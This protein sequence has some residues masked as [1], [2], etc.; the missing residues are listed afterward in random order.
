[1]GLFNTADEERQG[2]IAGPSA[3]KF[4]SRSRLPV[5]VLKNI[6][7]VADNPPSNFLDHR[8]FA[9]AIR[10]IQLAQNGLKGEGANLAVPGGAVLK[11]AFFEGI[12]GS[13]V[14][15]PPP[16]PQQQ[17]QQ[18]QQQLHQQ[19]QAPV[20]PSRQP[21]QQQP[22][23][24]PTQHPPPGGIPSSPSLQSTQMNHSA[25][26]QPPTP[27]RPPHP[28]SHPVGP[29]VG[30]GALTV[31]DPFTLTP[32]DQ[33]R[34]EALFAE[35]CKED[36]YVYG[37]EAVAFFGK[38]GLPPT[39]LGTI[40]NMS[41]YPVD[42]RLDK[43]EF[44]IAM[45]LIVCVSKKNLPLPSTL[46]LALK[47]LKSQRQLQ[48]QPMSL[49]PQ[50][51]QPQNTGYQPP[52]Q[53]HNIPAPPLVTTQQNMVNQSPMITPP[54]QTTSMGQP[55]MATS[56]NDNGQ[57]YG[58]S[59]S[60]PHANGGAVDN[61]PSGVGNL[62]GLPGPPPLQSQSASFSISDAFEGLVAGGGDAETVSTYRANT[63]PVPVTASFDT[64]TSG[65]H[66]PQPTVNHMPPSLSPELAP[67]ATPS[68]VQSSPMR[69]RGNSHRDAEP[70]RDTEELRLALQKLQA[71]NISLKARLATINGEEEDVRSE[72]VETVSQITK[73]SGE[74]TT[75]RAQLL[76]AKSR[77]LEVTGE[78]TAAKEKKK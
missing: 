2:Q 22:M 46:P 44:C 60:V 7:M 3:V 55:S 27:P 71:E 33:A 43:I 76:A 30:Y 18:Q 11:P 51:Q 32:N 68:V 48:P 13:I 53:G 58:S 40:W 31:Q 1:L 75:L 36:G 35:Q 41:D 21:N 37:S 24:P 72:L 65:F 56:V 50:Q 45:H 4:F 8:K 19:Q 78:L 63:P 34:Y 39:V 16:P 12:S 69:V 25:K 54:P 57:Q 70:H 59:W 9:V 23:Q 73:L 17:Q 15:L 14:P 49:P 62:S 64:N 77:L 29:T 66:A 67:I 26:M 6:W 47:Q 61:G 74:L 10:L 20:S 5:D 52:Q 42:N 28:H 38:S